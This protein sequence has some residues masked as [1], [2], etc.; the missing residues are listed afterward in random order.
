MADRFEP[1]PPSK[2]PPPPIAKR[3]LWLAAL[4]IAGVTVTAGAAYI[5]RGLLFI[6]Q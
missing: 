5:L 2:E 1:T 6:G 3:L 4:M